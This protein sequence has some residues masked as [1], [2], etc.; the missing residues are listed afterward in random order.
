MN[1][2]VL[3]T[4]CSGGGKTTLLKALEGRGYATVAEPGRRILAEEREGTGRALPWVDGAAFAKRAVEVARSDLAVMGNQKGL[5]FFDRGVV[6]AAVALDHATGLPYRQTLGAHRHYDSTV[7]LAPPWPEIFSQDDDRRHD[8]TAAKEE[9]QR[10]EAAL[11]ALGYDT[12]LLP[13]VPVAERVEC[14]LSR[15]KHS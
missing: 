14:V 5:V 8:L 6:D 7:F 2:F 3:I 4:G 11:E 9:F 13:K 10:L 12:C 1:R 15:L